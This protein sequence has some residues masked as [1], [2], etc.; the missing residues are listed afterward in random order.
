[1]ATSSSMSCG[2]CI[3]TCKDV[4]EAAFRL[5]TPAIEELFRIKDASSTGTC[6]YVLCD[7]S[8]RI[9]MLV[10]L[11]LSVVAILFTAPYWAYMYC[12]E[13]AEEATSSLRK[14]DHVRAMCAIL[15]AL[16]VVPLP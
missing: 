9:L 7:I 8:I 10:Q 6:K 16:F 12:F 14:S 2:G 3:D 11:A 1:M 13:N 5:P 15:C 4:L